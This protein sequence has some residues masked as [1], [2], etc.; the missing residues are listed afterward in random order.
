MA[1]CPVLYHA[2]YQDYCFGPEHPFSPVRLEMLWALLE[3]LRFVLEPIFGD[4]KLP[5]RFPVNYYNYH[6]AFLS[7]FGAFYERND[8]EIAALDQLYDNR[9]RQGVD[10]ETGD[11]ICG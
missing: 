4:I 1:S 3:A 7:S 6:V 2:T 5:S 8:P 10:P 11:W 9:F